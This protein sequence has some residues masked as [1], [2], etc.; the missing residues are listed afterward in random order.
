MLEGVFNVHKTKGPTSHDVVSRLRR[1]AGT[2]RVGHTGTLD[3]MAEGVLLCC[4]GRATRIVPWLVG[5]SKEYTGEITLGAVS[6]TYDAQGKIE[7][8]ADPAGIEPADIEKAFRSQT[9]LINQTAPPWSAVKVKGKKLYEYARKGEDVPERVRRVWVRQF[10]VLR[11]LTPKILFKATVESGTYI[12]SMAH[13]VGLELGCGAYLSAL[14]RTRVGAFAIEDAIQLDAMEPDPDAMLPLECLSIVEAL[15]HLPKMR[16]TSQAE[17]RLRFGSP[18]QWEGIA[19]SA[20][21]P[22]VGAPILVIDK[23]GDALAIVQ[24]ESP[25][26]P[27]RPLRVLEPAG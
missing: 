19:E 21:L 1:L 8:V 2:K 24:T 12:R 7:P 13:E 6:N 3:P 14:C 23:Q 10:D 27:F 25:E 4:V 26:A 22:P 11:Y 15:A 9:G 17:N 5:L 18:F 16:L 20:D